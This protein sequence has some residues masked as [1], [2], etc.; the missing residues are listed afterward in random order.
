M[1]I[2]RLTN[3]LMKVWYQ[4]TE[5]KPDW[6]TSHGV[7]E[8]KFREANVEQFFQSMKKLES[9]VLPVYA[10]PDFLDEL[11]LAQLRDLFLN[12]FSYRYEEIDQMFS[13]DMMRSTKTFVKQ[14]W[15]FD[16]QLPV[17]SV[18]QA[19]RNV[20]IMN[21]LQLILGRRVEMTP[22]IFAYSMLYPYTDNFVDDPHISTAEKLAF[23]HRFASRL[24]GKPV[25]PMNHQEQKIYQM[26][27]QIEGQYDRQRYPGVY[28]SLL[29]IHQAQTESMQ[30]FKQNTVSEED[31]LRICVAKGGASV[32]ADGYLIAGDLSEEEKVFLFGY[33]AYLQLLDDIQDVKEDLED[34]VMTAFSNVAQTQKLDRMVYKT[35]HFGEQVL[36]ASKALLG[37]TEM[38]FKALLQKSILL[39]FVE[40]VA[41]DEQFY[42]QEF[43]DELELVSPLSFAFVR[44]KRTLFTPQK[45]LLLEKFEKLAFVAQRKRI[46]TAG[47]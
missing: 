11:V 19:C 5:E 47:N 9:D 20:W 39:F 14:V 30:L 1:E 34:G 12:A 8:K 46:L 24:A 18:F 33:G 35:Y 2:H 4:T 44:S 7:A 45:H 36:S 23:S 28:E 26:V 10:E 16:P 38:D 15:S 32:L 29:G 17:V 6:G 31:A 37:R 43:Q 3:Q 41:V 25:D 27:E 42:S 40:S 21:G 22:A 13:P